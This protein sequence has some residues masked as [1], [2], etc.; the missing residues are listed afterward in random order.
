MPRKKKKPDYVGKWKVPRVR[1]MTR[2]TLYLSKTSIA[3]L[4]S[5]FFFFFSW[6]LPALSK[7]KPENKKTILDEG[8]ALPCQF[9]R[10]PPPPPPPPIAQESA[11]YVFHRGDSG[12]KAAGGQNLPMPLHRA[13]F[14]LVFF[15]FKIACTTHR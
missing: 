1:C 7:T 13:I 4:P 8:G 10:L 14:A 6:E 15:R 5:H 2:R 9:C 12:D 3:V 11:A